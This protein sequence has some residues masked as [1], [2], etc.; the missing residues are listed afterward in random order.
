[1][2]LKFSV[3]APP[4]ALRTARIRVSTLWCFGGF[5]TAIPAASA[6]W[7]VQTTCG[8]SKTGVSSTVSLDAF[9]Y[10][11]ATNLSVQVSVEPY[12][13]RIPGALVAVQAEAAK[14]LAAVK[15][16]IGGARKVAG[17]CPFPELHAR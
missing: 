1:L 9:N 12:V 15:E 8:I 6:D 5:L 16:A 2:T 13:A 11:H 7:C 10:A 17:A 14:Q 4:S 3:T